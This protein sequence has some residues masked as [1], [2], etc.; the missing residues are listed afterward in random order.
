[1]DTKKI[2]FESFRDI[3]DTSNVTTYIAKDNNGDLMAKSYNFGKTLT[4]KNK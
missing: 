4:K 3:A 1:M 2:C